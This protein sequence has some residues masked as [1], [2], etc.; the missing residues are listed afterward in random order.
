VDKG[1]AILSLELRDF[2]NYGQLR[3][4]F[5][6]DLNGM[7]GPNGAGKTNIL[8]ALYYLCTTKGYFNGTE[9]YN[10]R[11]GT[12]LMQLK[13]L[14]ALKGYDYQAEIRVAK[15]KKKELLINKARENKLSEYV[16]KFPVVIIA[17]DD[18]QI[19]LGGSEERRRLLD[20]GLCQADSTYTDQLLRY[21]KILQQR[22]A[23][24]KQIADSD[25]RQ[26]SLL[27]TID[28]MLAGLAQNIYQQ[29]K[30]FCNSY[31]SIAAE[32]YQRI[33]GAA[34]AASIQYHSHLDEYPLEIWL[35]KNR[36]KD[37]LLQRTT[38][39]VH[40]DDLD[41]QLDGHP[42]KK[43]GSQGQQKTFVV[44][45]KMGLYA[46]LKDRKNLYPALL[47]DDIF[48]KFDEERVSRLFEWLGDG[49]K[50]QIFISDTH[51]ERLE[52]FMSG[53]GRPYQLFQVNNGEVYEKRR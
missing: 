2:K 50:G 51:P 52:A 16:G 25:Q 34:E 33:S 8:D 22:N 23:L 10:F 40:L 27:D 39:G 38:K 32:V 7:A 31:S 13:G 43:V 46:L 36:D 3:L 18:N 26:D 47:L 48:E 17:P 35:K 49:H 53:S 1:M 41:L 5:C 30:E 12:D 4:E 24:L 44:A 28:E 37:I 20:S 19:I 21:N 29:R 45:L 11:H 42:V 15:G 14:I 9:Q 6:A